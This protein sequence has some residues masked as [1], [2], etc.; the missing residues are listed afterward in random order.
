MSSHSNRVLGVKYSDASDQKKER[1]IL[2]ISMNHPRGPGR[3]SSSKRIG[4]SISTDAGMQ[5]PPAT[6]RLQS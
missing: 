5:L 2:V 4:R 6:R 3:S 1:L